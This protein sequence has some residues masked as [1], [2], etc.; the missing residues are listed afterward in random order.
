LLAAA[1]LTVRA[2]SCNFGNQPAATLL[3]PFFEVDLDDSSG[4]TTLLAIANRSETQST[5]SHVV[6]WTDW[7]IPS[8]SFDL[9]LGRGDVQ[10]LNLRDLFLTGRA[11][12]TGS[13]ALI[14]GC[15]T[16]VG[17]LFINPPVFQSLHSGQSTLGGCFASPR[18]D[19]GRVTGYVTVD[20]AERCSPA[21][22]LP[23][24]TGYF[25]PG[26]R[27]ASTNNLLWGD[28]FLVDPDDDFAQG[29]SAVHVLADPARFASGGRTFYGKFVGGSGLDA[30]LPLASRWSVRYLAGGGFN[31]G[32][33]LLVWRD[34]GVVSTAP[35]TCGGNP[36]WFPLRQAGVAVWNENG[37]RD[38]LSENDLV[39]L[40]T[41]RL[42]VDDIFDPD[43]AFGWLDLDL[44]RPN[45]RSQ[46]WVLYLAS[47]EGRY[48]V[49]QSGNRVDDPCAP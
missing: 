39:P 41:Q 7:G 22:K 33:E 5:L 28:F 25:G 23:T 19:T 20:V 26:T 31:G 10:T 27:V 43:S 29:E 42:P 16:V 45:T 2:Q 32:T 30:R 15:T 24:D 38:V 21:V 8:A 12:E 14:P 11:P 3:F 13:A 35:V 36:A 18:S 1:P 34:T 47:A 40:A 48:S 4:L 49:L 9:F 44:D 17:G 46:A 6:F 37:Q